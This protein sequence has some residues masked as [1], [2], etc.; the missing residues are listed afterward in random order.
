MAAT[1]TLSPRGTSLPVVTLI[2]HQYSASFA[3]ALSI[4]WAPPTSPAQRRRHPRRRERRRSLCS[5]RRSRRGAWR[6]RRI[7]AA[8]P[9]SGGACGW[10]YPR[11]PRW[12]DPVRL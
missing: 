12:W 6:M 1:R 8:A 10:L 2:V 5:I 4:E 7:S 11:A 9:R 3:A